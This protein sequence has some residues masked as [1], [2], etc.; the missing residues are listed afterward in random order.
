MIALGRWRASS[1]INCLKDHFADQKA[2]SSMAFLI[3]SSKNDEID[4]FALDTD[5][6]IY[7][8]RLED[9]KGECISYV[10]LF[11]SYDINLIKKTSV[12]LWNY[13]GNKEV[14]F[15]EKEKR[16][17]SDLGIKI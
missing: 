17:L 3:A 6:V 16:L 7:V 5:S 13:Y 4:V 11:S 12:K 1:Y 10:S 15:D 8:D 2:V 14:S 9:V